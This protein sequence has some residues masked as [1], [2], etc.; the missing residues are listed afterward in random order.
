MV[1][2]FSMHT[3]QFAFV[4]YVL[5]LPLFVH[6][7]FYL[8]FFILTFRLLLSCSVSVAACSVVLHSLR[9]AWLIFA[10]FRV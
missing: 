10:I 8:H 6:S 7:C 1:L 5:S 4:H 2:Q 9:Y 3:V